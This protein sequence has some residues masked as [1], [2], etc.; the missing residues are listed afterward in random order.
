MLTMW[1]NAGTIWGNHKQQRGP[2]E[3]IFIEEKEDELNKSFDILCESSVKKKN[4]MLKNMC[5]MKN[6]K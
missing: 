5:H 3:Y 1:K 6:K 2:F 4:W